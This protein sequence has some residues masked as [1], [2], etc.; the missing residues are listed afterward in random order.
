MLRKEARYD[1]YPVYPPLLVIL[2]VLFFSLNPVI[3]IG[4]IEGAFIMGMGYHLMED[5]IH[6][7]KTG[8]IINAGTWVRFYKDNAQ[9]EVQEEH[10]VAISSMH[11]LLAL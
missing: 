6:D 3:D 5:I 9:S 8:R 4:Q 2:V 7:K 1:I 10:C 11:I